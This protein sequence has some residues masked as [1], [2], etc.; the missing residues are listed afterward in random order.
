MAVCLYLLV[1]L[2]C[3]GNTRLHPVHVMPP[4]QRARPQTAV[5]PAPPQ[6]SWGALG[7]QAGRAAPY[8][9]QAVHPR[10]G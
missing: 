4:I 2:L 8:G 7:S 5:G 3:N 10:S 9:A 1:W 6:V